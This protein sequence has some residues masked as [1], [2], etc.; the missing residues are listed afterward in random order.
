MLI[1][2]FFS[3]VSLVLL[4]SG[5]QKHRINAI[6]SN[7]TIKTYVLYRVSSY[8]SVMII[9]FIKLWSYLDFCVIELVNIR[10]N[11]LSFVLVLVIVFVSSCVNINSI[12][13]LSI[14]DNSLFLFYI[15]IL[16][17]SM[18]TFVLTNDLLI[19][20]LNR[21]LLGIISY[22]LINYRSSKV[23]SSIKAVI[24]N[25]VGDI[26]YLFQKHKND[27]PEIMTE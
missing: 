11:S 8:T 7:A 20:F 10:I 2:L 13:Y 6:N 4:I 19:S 12:D 23:N 9:L 24:F 17:L 5:L 26:F 18:I 27:K 15:S 16:Q 3:A 14:M 1:S 21:D 22:L 25:K